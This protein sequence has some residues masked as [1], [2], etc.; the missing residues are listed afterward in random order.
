MSYRDDAS[1]SSASIAGPVEGQIAMHRKRMKGAP[2]VI[3][4]TC[5]VPVGNLNSALEA[6]RA[7]LCTSEVRSAW[8]P[9]MDKQETLEVV[10]PGVRVVRAYSKIGWPSRCATA[11]NTLIDVLMNSWVVHATTS[12]CKKSRKKLAN[13]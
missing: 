5:T 3:R 13:A 4:A 9:T 1:T 7:A 8:D 6:F 10:E 12:A 11:H 2:D